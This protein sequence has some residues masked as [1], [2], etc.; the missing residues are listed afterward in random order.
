MK[1]LFN[2][3]VYSPSIG[4]WLAAI[5]TEDSK[6]MGRWLK[7]CRATDTVAMVT[8]GLGPDPE[9]F[10]GEVDDYLESNDG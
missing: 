5:R 2:G 6:Q 8:L 9:Q 4:V 3:V 1:P 7:L 10:I